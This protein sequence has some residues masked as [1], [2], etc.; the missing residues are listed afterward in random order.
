MRRYH[1]DPIWSDLESDPILVLLTARPTL[2]LQFNSDLYE[3][4][5]G[6][7][8]GSPLGAQMTN[9]FMCSIAEKLA[10]ENK[11][12]NFYRRYVDDTFD[13]LPDLTA[14]TYFLSALNNAH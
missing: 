10:H 14:A 6:F 1:S 8:M 11:L 9:T 7:A 13:L 4:I 2:I 5:D 12:P 3:Q